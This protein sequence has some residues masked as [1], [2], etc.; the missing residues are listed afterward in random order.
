MTN[1][2]L[3]PLYSMFNAPRAFV[4][5]QERYPEASLT[6]AHDGRAG[7]GIEKMA[8]ELKTAQHALHRPRAA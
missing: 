3:E 5:I 6:I 7:R 1:R 8:G 4:I 2:I